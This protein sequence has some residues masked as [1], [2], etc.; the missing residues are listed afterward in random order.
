[1]DSVNVTGNASSAEVYDESRKQTNRKEAWFRIVADAKTYD[2][3]ASV[4]CASPLNSK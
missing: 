1:M 4:K 3:A 2:N